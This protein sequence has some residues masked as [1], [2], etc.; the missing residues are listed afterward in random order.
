[1]RQVR[2]Y[3]L[4]RLSSTFSCSHLSRIELFPVVVKWCADDLI[5]F[6]PNLRAALSVSSLYAQPIGYAGTCTDKFTIEK[7]ILSN[8]ANPSS[9]SQQQTTSTIQASADGIDDDATNGVGRTPKGHGPTAT[10]A[11]GALKS[12]VA[13]INATGIE[14]GPTFFSFP[15]FLSLLFPSPVCSRIL[16][17]W[18]QPITTRAALAAASL[19]AHPI[20]YA[21]RALIH[22]L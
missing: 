8:P 10:E 14:G 20:G 6:P 7:V 1:M 2:L 21:A 13:D 3:D 16:L 18:A 17:T 15:P 9:S 19:H 4:A 5:F 22:L 11:H 12:D